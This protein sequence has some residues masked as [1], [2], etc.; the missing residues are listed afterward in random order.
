VRPEHDKAA[1]DGCMAWQHAECWRAHGACAACGAGPGGA[2]APAPARVA[3]PAA[4][5]QTPA[6]APAGGGPRCARRSCSTAASPYSS[7]CAFHQATV[8][9]QRDARLLL[10]LGLAN[11]VLFFSL[12]AAVGGGSELM[13]LLALLFGVPAT[14][15][16]AYR[17]F[18]VWRDER[19]R[20][21]A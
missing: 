17:R 16:G 15:F 5:K 2:P 14:L 19:L 11:L 21:R 7:W 3:P 20:D 13:L 4:A 12:H 9:R 6:P 10:G 1:C 8:A 18:A